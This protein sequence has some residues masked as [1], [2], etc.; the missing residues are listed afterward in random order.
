MNSAVPTATNYLNAMAPSFSASNSFLFTVGTTLD[1]VQY[2]TY[3]RELL[4]TC[5]VPISTLLE[6][7]VSR[8][9]SNVVTDLASAGWGGMM[10]T[11][12]FQGICVPTPLPNLW[13]K[14]KSKLKKGG[15]LE[16]LSRKTETQESSMK[17]WVL[18][19][20]LENYNTS[21]SLSASS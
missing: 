7:A 6:G 15:I 1:M 4:F 13:I 3:L 14:F 5:T 8:N 21:S 16:L 19:E 20:H 11:M 12:Y 18:N 2:L 9:S 10:P 17:N